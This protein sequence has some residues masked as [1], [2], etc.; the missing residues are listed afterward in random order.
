MFGLSRQDRD[1][2][3]RGARDAADAARRIDDHTQECTRRYEAQAKA[4][5]RV[6]K[7]VGGVAREQ[8]KLLWW[9]IA[10]LLGVVGF[11]LKDAIHFQVHL[12]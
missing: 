7:A 9:I 10:L 2:W 6:E 11:V 5:E 3:D 8:R 1:R 12:G 4:V